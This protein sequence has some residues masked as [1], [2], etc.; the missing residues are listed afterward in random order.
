MKSNSKHVRDAAKAY[1]VGCIMSVDP[2]NWGKETD[3][4]K[5]RLE[6][7]IDEF[8][9]AANHENNL[10]RYPNLQQRFTNWRWGLPS[11]LP[12]EFYSNAI[13]DL[14]TAWGL[15]NDKG[16]DSSQSIDLYDHI[17]YSEITKLLTKNGLEL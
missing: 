3:D 10:R 1:L 16:Y 8:R 14:L 15:P 17:I 7:I 5:T 11:S 2:Q 12:I 4:L 9:G 13:V 6:I